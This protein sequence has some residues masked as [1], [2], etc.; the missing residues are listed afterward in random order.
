[1]VSGTVDG[2]TKAMVLI[3]DTMCSEVELKED[4]VKL[5]VRL[6][7]PNS[8]CGAI[9]GKGG[10]TIKSFVTASHADILVLQMDTRIVGL[11]DRLVTITGTFGP[12][13]KAIELIL[14]KLSQDDQYPP[15]LSSPFSYAAQNT[16]ESTC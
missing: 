2:I 6:V 3:L 10:A 4:E 8:S 11:H 9:I 1:M 15:N 5:K 16:N 13:L 12:Q 14:N 7:V